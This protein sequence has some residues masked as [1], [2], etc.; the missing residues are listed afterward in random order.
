MAFSFIIGASQQKRK[1]LTLGFEPYI[2]PTGFDRTAQSVDIFEV[3]KAYYATNNLA[4]YIYKVLDTINS[5]TETQGKSYKYGYTSSG[6]DYTY[7]LSNNTQTTQTYSGWTTTI[8]VI[9]TTGF[10]AS[11]TLYIGNGS[12]FNYTSITDGTTFTGGNQNIQQSSGSQVYSTKYTITFPSGSTKKWVIVN[13]INTGAINCNITNQRT[14]V[15]WLYC[16]P[17]INSIVTSAGGA[18]GCVTKWIHIHK[19]S[20]I[21]SYPHTC[22]YRSVELTGNLYLSPT[23]TSIGPATS[24]TD[25]VGY[26][27][28][29]DNKL[30]GA[31]IIPSNIKSISRDSFQGCSGFTSLTINGPV[32]FIGYQAFLQCTGMVGELT[33]PDTCVDIGYRAFYGCNKFTSLI[34]GSSTKTIGVESFYLCTAMVGT[35]TIPASVESIGINAFTST[36][37]DTIVSYSSDFDVSDN[38]LYDVSASPYIKAN[39]GARLRS[40]SLTLRNDTTEILTQCFLSNTLR[41]GNIVIPDTVTSIGVNAFKGST[42]FTGTLTI[43]SAVSRIETSAF[44]SCPL[45]GTLSIPASVTF[46]GEAAFALNNFSAITNSSSYCDASDNVLY[47]L[48]VSGEVKANISARAYTGTLTLRAD[49]TRILDYCFLN[50]VNRSGSLTFPDTL[51]EIRLKSFGNCAGFSGD[52]IFPA[53]LATVGKNGW[54][55]DTF[56]GCNGFWDSLIIQNPNIWIGTYGNPIQMP[57]IGRNS[58]GVQLPVGYAGA[59]M[60]FSASA[61][62]S[63][64][65]MNQSIINIAS[66]TK[67]LKIGATNKARLLAA[68]PNAVTDAAARGITIV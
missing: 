42:G 64:D 38:V 33:I 47:D 62:L 16:G 51:V 60:D 14:A 17:K 7:D 40:G 8:K 29:G 32:T 2:A 65:T 10:P 67:T 53:A 9:S 5:V 41:T 18:L 45:T 1:G 26:A 58:G 3:Y 30:T 6:V 61:F 22:H 35:L 52:L 25:N 59:W 31:L 57:N 27:F 36:S 50:N 11:G 19:L 48:S 4:Q 12:V 56:Y 20:N 43:G 66:G 37:F 44:D 46:V 68:Y 63:A 49:T 21:T 54:Q 39:Y 15:E 23:A 34:I 28:M 24:A 55:S 13:D